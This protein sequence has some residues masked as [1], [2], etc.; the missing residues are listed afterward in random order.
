MALFFSA[1]LAAVEISHPPG[2]LYVQGKWSFSPS[3]DT[4]PSGFGA[5]S[6]GQYLY[7]SPMGQACKRN[8][9]VH[10]GGAAFWACSTAYLQNRSYLDS[11]ECIPDALMMPAYIVDRLNSHELV[12]IPDTCLQLTAHHYDYLTATQETFTTDITEAASFGPTKHGIITSAHADFTVR[13]T[14]SQPPPTL[15]RG[16]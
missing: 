8:L 2:P 11:G 13:R 16:Y 4:S 14:G 10:V 3:G 15:H 6:L 5:Y 9:T 7:V 12:D 1:L